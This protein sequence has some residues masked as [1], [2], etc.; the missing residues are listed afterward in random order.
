MP[1]RRTPLASLAYDRE[2]KVWF[3]VDSAIPGLSGEADT[4]EALI[5]RLPGLIADLLEENG[6]VVKNAPL[7]KGRGRRVA[8]KNTAP[9]AV[10]KRPVLKVSARKRAGRKV[11]PR[12]SARKVA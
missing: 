8:A 3:I 11:A 6:V 10:R 5:A 4:R 1:A 12:K 2:A 7:T 9:K